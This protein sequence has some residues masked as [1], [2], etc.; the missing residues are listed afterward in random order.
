MSEKGAWIKYNAVSFSAKNYSKLIARS[1]SK[2]GGVIKVYTNSVND[3]NLV[4]EITIPK[5]SEWVNVETKIKKK[6]NGKHDLI[7]L[8]DS[9]KTIEFD[10]LKFSK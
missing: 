8:S 7:V 6:L 9:N 5:S 4:S 1:L 3:E 2:E 10:W